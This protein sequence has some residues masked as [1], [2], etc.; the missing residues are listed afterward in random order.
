VPYPHTRDGRRNFLVVSRLLKKGE[1]SK[2]LEQN[3]EGHGNG[4]IK[5]E[6]KYQLRELQEK[7]R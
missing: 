3:G 2:P 7:R 6:G 4:M 5:R 1:G